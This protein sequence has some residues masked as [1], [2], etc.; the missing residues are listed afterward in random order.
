MWT[1]HTQLHFP[2]LSYTTVYTRHCQHLTQPHLHLHNPHTCSPRTDTQTHT[3]FS[4]LSYL[5]VCP[6]GSTL[7]PASSRLFQCPFWTPASIIDGG[8]VSRQWRVRY[9]EHLRECVTCVDQSGQRLRQQQQE[10]R[11]P[12][13]GLLP[14]RRFFLVDKPIRAMAELCVSEAVNL[15]ISAA[16]RISLSLPLYLEHTH[17]LFLYLAHSHS[18]SPSLSLSLSLAIW[19]SL[20]FHNF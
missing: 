16:E 2:H 10:A 11:L 6:L 3:H 4:Y 5:P 17:S 15:G 14:S 7:P 18:P 13:G 12:S 19:L 1:I 9:V 8:S 20:L